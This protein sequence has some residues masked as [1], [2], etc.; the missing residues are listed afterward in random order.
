M[1]E[2]MGIHFEFWTISIT[3]FF[4]PKVSG[5]KVLVPYS[6]AVAMKRIIV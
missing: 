1:S 6:D 3:N 2:L 4:K 5:K